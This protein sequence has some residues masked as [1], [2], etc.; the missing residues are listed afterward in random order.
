MASGKSEEMDVHKMRCA[1]DPIYRIL[2]DPSSV[3]IEEETGEKVVFLDHI[4]QLS[5]KFI[6]KKYGEPLLQGRAVERMYQ[7]LKEPFVDTTVKTFALFFF[8]RWEHPLYDAIVSMYQNESPYTLNGGSRQFQRLMARIEDYID[9]TFSFPYNKHN[10]HT[11]V[12]DFVACARKEY[13]IGPLY[14]TAP[15]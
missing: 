3:V 13:F 7:L 11:I 8:L 10:I 1:V 4:I 6:S 2:F 12:R 14:A 15:Q 5:I 9:K